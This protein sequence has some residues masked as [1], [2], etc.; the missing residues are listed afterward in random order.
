MMLL[1]PWVPLNVYDFACWARQTVVALSVVL[2]YRPMRRCPSSSRSCTRPRA[3]AAARPRRASRPCAG[4][5]RPAA[6]ASTSG[7]RCGACASTRSPAPSGGSSIA[8]RPTARGAGSSRPWVYSLIA[9]HLRGYPLDHPVIQRGLDGLE[10]LHDR[11][12]R[13][14]AA[15]GLPVAGLGHGA[16]GDRAGRRRRSRRPRGA[17]RGRRLAARRGDPRARR[18]GGP[19]A[20]TRAR[21]A[22]R[23]S[24]RTSTTPTSTTPPRSCWRCARSTHPD[25]GGVQPAIDRGVAL[26][27]WGCR[28]RDGGWGGVRRRQLPAR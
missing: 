17:R 11:R 1:P 3:V 9:L 2:A 14:A 15:R 22:G 10:A 21:R 12:R 19:A 6:A 20:A 5:A 26:A 25:A 4:R 24:S 18:L 28:A 23:S 27:R 13:R 7:G 16:G 8:R